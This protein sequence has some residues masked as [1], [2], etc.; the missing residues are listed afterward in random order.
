MIGYSRAGRCWWVPPTRVAWLLR[1]TWPVQ[2]ALAEPPGRGHGDFRL[3]AGIKVE[4]SREAGSSGLPVPRIGDGQARAARAHPASIVPQ[5]GWEPHPWT[6]CRRRGGAVQDERVARCNPAQQGGPRPSRRI[7]P[8]WSK[9]FKRNLLV[10][11]NACRG[12]RSTLWS[13]RR[14]LSHN[15]FD[16]RGQRVA[17]RRPESAHRAASP[18]YRGTWHL[19]SAS[20]LLEAKA[21]EPGHQG[22]PGQTYS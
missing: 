14:S 18:H 22:L 13:V 16:G 10:P 7:A 1:P 21:S 9:C 2:V 20:A 11:F 17:V 15:D 12:R 8:Q 5:R 19:R 4:L 3:A 6:V